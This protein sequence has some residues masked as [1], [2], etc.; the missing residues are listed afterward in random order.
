LRFW[1]NLIGSMMRISG[2][3]VALFGVSSSAFGV[4]IIVGIPIVISGVV[5]YLLGRKFMISARSDP[6]G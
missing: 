4:P 6:H 2:V 1:Q 3:I 5:L